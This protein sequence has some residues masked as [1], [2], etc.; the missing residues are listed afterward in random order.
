MFWEWAA[1]LQVPLIGLLGAW[2]TWALSRHEETLQGNLRRFPSRFRRWLRQ[3]LGTR[4][5][6]PRHERPAKRRH[7]R[8]RP[9][10]GSHPTSK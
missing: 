2:A 4:K 9:P 10:L 3:H 7:S 1:V 5:R 8:Y 6:H